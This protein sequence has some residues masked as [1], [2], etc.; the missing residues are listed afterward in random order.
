MA[1]NT[2]T[3]MEIKS[4]TSQLDVLFVAISHVNGE[5]IFGLC[6]CLLLC[7]TFL[8]NP[9]FSFLHCFTVASLLTLSSL[10]STKMKVSYV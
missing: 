4:R 6:L 3:E 2:T 8:I 10:L 5:K 9:L 1:W 7:K